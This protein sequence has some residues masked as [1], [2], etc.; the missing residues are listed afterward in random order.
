MAVMLAGVPNDSRMM[1]RSEDEMHVRV[2]SDVLVGQHDIYSN[3]VNIAARLAALARD[4]RQPEHRRAGPLAAGN[5]RAR[6]GPAQGWLEGLAGRQ[7]LGHGM[8]VVA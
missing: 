4:L 2:S 3:S 5:R 8:A 6:E 7:G 1:S